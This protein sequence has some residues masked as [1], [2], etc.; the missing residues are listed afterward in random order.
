[1]TS[2]QAGI[3]L[4]VTINAAVLG[5]YFRAMP[6]FVL[7]LIPS[8]YFLM[9]IFLNYPLRALVL[10]HLEPESFKD[11]DILNALAFTTAFTLIFVVTTILLV[12]A[13]RYAPGA[14]ISRAGS[15]RRPNA[16]FR[17]VVIAVGVAILVG[18]AYRFYS[19]RIL[20][21]FESREDL[22]F[23]PW[24]VLLGA[25]HSLIWFVFLS[26]LILYRETA[27][28]R[29][30][31]LFLVLT[32][33]YLLETVLATAKGP[34]LYL[35]ILY[36]IYKS[37]FEMR[38]NV[39]L[40]LGIGLLGLVYAAYTYLA[41]YF[42]DVRSGFSLVGVTDTITG[43][44]ENIE[45][46][47]EIGVQGTISRFSY[48]DGLILLMNKGAW[49]DQGY[50]SLGTVTELINLIPRFLY[51]DRPEI[52]F[53][54][55]LSG[56][57]WDSGSVAENPIGRIGE[58]FFVFRY[59]GVVIA[60]IYASIMFFAYRLLLCSASPWKQGVYFSMFFIYLLPD[61]YFFYNV[62]PMLHGLIILLLARLMVPG[63]VDALR[64]Y[65]LSDSKLVD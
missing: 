30:L 19:G 35:L 49:L 62:K 61:A 37:Y 58:A 2:E 23:S 33:A 65:R 13:Y 17:H 36:V 3:Y 51:P 54:V 63:F 11:G 18:F 64:F 21:L 32:G 46:W 50:F 60:P 12:Q 27:R 20:G 47:S 28:F 4:L 5:Y 26:S 57:V 7:W 29:Y 55:Y 22:L 16:T 6:T 8:T 52:N 9:V 48:L 41:R 53:N 10:L 43:V 59:A 56:E 15:P 40:V 14:W 38:I 24:E 39:R 31:V 25:S 1:M 45:H 34:I 42:G 44:I